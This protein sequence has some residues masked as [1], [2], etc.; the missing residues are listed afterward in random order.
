MAIRCDVILSWQATP[1]Q[2]AALGAALWRWCNWGAGNTGIYQFLDNQAL[3][4]LIAGRFPTASL[5]PRP[6][7]QRG[8]YFG[9]EDKVSSD[10]RASIAS[11][12]RAMPAAGIEDILVEG[13]S[14][15][16]PD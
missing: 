2:L 16:L 15:N 12:R 11:L 7:D 10:R 14:W 5:T 8:V 3:A 4:D 13:S 9:V 6:A 1:A